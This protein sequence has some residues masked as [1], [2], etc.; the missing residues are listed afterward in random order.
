MLRR[1]GWLAGCLILGSTLGGLPS[2][3][4]EIQGDVGRGAKFYSDNCARCHKAR[5]PMEHRDRD[6]SVVMTHMRITA[7]LPGQQ[8]RDI[9]A[10]LWASNNPPRFE[11]AHA[12][13][14]GDEL[15][16]A[17]GCRGCHN[18]G[19]EGGTLG[20]KL[21]DVLERRDETWIRH[22]IL[23][24]SETNSATVMP[25]FGLTNSQVDAMM[26]ALRRQQR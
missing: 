15:L 17:Y 21:D 20:P 25:T 6:W 5:P 23:R 18:I 22:K 11:L 3:G 10:F 19:G 1:F 4:E 13:V 9:Q 16:Q 12:P 26:E 24:P 7:G 2:R 14:G 8:A